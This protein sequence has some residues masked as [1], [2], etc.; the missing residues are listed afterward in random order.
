MR[1]RCA[2]RAMAIISLLINKSGWHIALTVGVSIVLCASMVQRMMRD[3]VPGQPWRTANALGVLSVTQLTLSIEIRRSLTI[4]I[5]ALKISAGAAT[6]PSANASVSP[7]KMK[8]LKNLKK[9]K[10]EIKK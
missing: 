6:S 2:V 10:K 4:A 9:E 8:K 7:K 1:T 3:R 5:S